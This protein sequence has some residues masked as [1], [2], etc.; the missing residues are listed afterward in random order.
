MKEFEGRFRAVPKGPFAK[1]RL[2]KSWARG[3]LQSFVYLAL[4]TAPDTCTAAT[5]MAP[6]VTKIFLPFPKDAPFSLG[7]GAG[8]V[9]FANLKRLTLKNARLD[10]FAPLAQLPSD[11]R[12]LAPI[13]WTVAKEDSIS[14]FTTLRGS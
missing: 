1:T 5:T 13:A 3:N 10:D 2:A 8:F 7:D 11:I 4:L 12:G 9:R 6:L 14:H